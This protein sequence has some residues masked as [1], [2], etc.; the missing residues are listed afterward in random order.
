MTPPVTAGTGTL[1][2]RKVQLGL[3]CST[4]REEPGWRFHRGNGAQTWGVK[5]SS[6][7]ALLLVPS[8]PSSPLAA[9]PSGVVQVQEETI[10]P[11]LGE[12]LIV[13]PVH[14]PWQRAHTQRQSFPCREFSIFSDLHGT[15]VAMLEVPKML[16]L[17]PC[18]VSLGGSPVPPQWGETAAP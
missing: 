16:L 3:T 5:Q 14:V 17:S 11:K 15:F 18:W 6:E 9:S 12:H 2:G 4:G 10:V 13:V 8:P 1:L 7:P